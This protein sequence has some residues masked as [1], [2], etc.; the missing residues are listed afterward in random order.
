MGIFFKLAISLFLGIYY[1]L[2]GHF[3][4]LE[5]DLNRLSYNV[6]KEK[7]RKTFLIVMRIVN[8]VFFAILAV[9]ALV[10]IGSQID[11][12]EPANIV[13]KT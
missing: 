11:L 6:V 10:E 5:D 4:N 8:A 9:M 1:F 13:V 2:P 3:E 12:D 7:T